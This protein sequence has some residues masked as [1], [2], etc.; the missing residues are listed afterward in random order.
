MGR[1]EAGVL[2]LTI[3]LSW[4]GVAIAQSTPLPDVPVAAWPAGTAAAALRVG[5]HASGTW[6]LGPFAV[7]LT[8][9]GVRVAAD[10]RTLW[11]SA[12]GGFVAAGAGDPGIVGGRGGFY[13][14]RA[15]FSDCWRRQSVLRASRHGR[16]MTLRGR[17]AG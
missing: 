5:A 14:V 4:P 7:S 1:R 12:R 6:R 13:G 15:S 11:S 9:R 16:V 8:A 10:R 3:A 2:G 17:L